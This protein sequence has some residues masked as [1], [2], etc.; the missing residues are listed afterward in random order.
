MRPTELFK[1]LNTS[2]ARSQQ[3][4]DFSF[5]F[6]FYPEELRYQIISNFKPVYRAKKFI[7]QLIGPP[8]YQFKNCFRVWLRIALFARRSQQLVPC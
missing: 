6:K 2:L 8:E 4:S 1:N 5:L 7:V 3:F